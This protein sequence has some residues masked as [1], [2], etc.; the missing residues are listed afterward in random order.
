MPAQ[1]GHDKARLKPSGCFR[2]PQSPKRSVGAV[3]RARRRRNFFLQ[4]SRAVT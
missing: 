2:E 4:Q 3:A 1:G